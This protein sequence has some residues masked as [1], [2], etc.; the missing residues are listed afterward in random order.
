[1][2]FFICILWIVKF[3]LLFLNFHFKWFLPFKSER[4]FQMNQINILLWFWIKNNKIIFFLRGFQKS[5]KN[6]A[7]KWVLKK[8]QISK[9][10]FI[11]SN[12]TSVILFWVPVN[13]CWT[14][15]AYLCSLSNKTL[16]YRREVLWK[17]I[18]KVTNMWQTVC[19]KRDWTKYFR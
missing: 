16:I 8:I 15:T 17:R 9:S 12:C 18:L 1:M 4:L 13:R 5:F 11:V 2:K 3:Y 7:H 6:Q 19:H 14:C 10:D